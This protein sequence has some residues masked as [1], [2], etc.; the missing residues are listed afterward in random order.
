MNH[1]HLR[2]ETCSSFLHGE[3]KDGTKRV[4]MIIV[5]PV[6]NKDVPAADADKACI[7]C[8]T[9]EPTCAALPC[10]HLNFAWGVRGMKERG[11]CFFTQVLVIYGDTMTHHPHNYN[12]AHK[13][14]KGFP[15]VGIDSWN[16]SLITNR[17]GEMLFM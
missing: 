8:L 16:D 2:V 4:K 3:D 17:Q 14:I 13:S 6:S 9:N 7:I 10:G 5:P 11:T 12:R 15:W 1:K